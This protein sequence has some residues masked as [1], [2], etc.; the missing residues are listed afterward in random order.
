MTEGMSKI[1]LGLSLSFINFALK[2]SLAVPHFSPHPF[3]CHMQH[4]ALCR[5]CVWAEVR[6]RSIGQ[7]HLILIERMKRKISE[8]VKMKSIPLNDKKISRN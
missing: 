2:R 6:Y 7:V 1:A 4:Q 8:R 3:Q 5:K